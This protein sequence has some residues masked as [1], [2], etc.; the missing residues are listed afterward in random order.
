MI[1]VLVFV[2]WVGLIGFIFWAS[3]VQSRR[4]SE[5]VARIRARPVVARYRSN[6]EEAAVFRKEQEA[7]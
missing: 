3:R 2:L 4:T 7:G 1:W 6:G 5:L